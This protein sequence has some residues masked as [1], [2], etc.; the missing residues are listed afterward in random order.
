MGAK[1]EKYGRG[2]DILVLIG[3]A[4]LLSAVV[5]GLP[6]AMLGWVFTDEEPGLGWYFLG[7]AVVAP[8]FF[9]HMLGDPHDRS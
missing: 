3:M 2:L 9:G 5:G 1:W 8:Y 6:V 7:A 4:T